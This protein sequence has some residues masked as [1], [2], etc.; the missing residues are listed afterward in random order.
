MVFPRYVELM[1][2]AGNRDMTKVHKEIM[3]MFKPKVIAQEKKDLT[4]T[5]K[6]IVLR[7]LILV[8]K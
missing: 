3:K 1:V 5:K 2:D 8:R 6:M 4:K 7:R